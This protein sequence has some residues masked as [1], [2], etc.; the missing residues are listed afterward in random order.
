MR[1]LEKE[2]EL[3]MNESHDDKRRGSSVTNCLRFSLLWLNQGGKALESKVNE[4]KEKNEI[5]RN[6]TVEIEA[7]RSIRISTAPHT[8]QVTMTRKG[9][10]EYSSHICMSG[11]SIHFILCF[12]TSEI[13]TYVARNNHMYNIVRESNA[14]YRTVDF[15]STSCHTTAREGVLEYAISSM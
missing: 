10:L 5:M 12:I 7:N 8:N 3:D 2:G 6:E 15:Y 11:Q 1:I 13:S 14:S 9:V 4:A